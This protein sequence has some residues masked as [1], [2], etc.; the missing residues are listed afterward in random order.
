MPT[1]VFI[2]QGM[3]V[4]KAMEIIEKR[5]QNK[6]QYHWEVKAISVNG[7]NSC[8]RTIER[9]K[10]EIAKKY[11][12]L[13]LEMIQKDVRGISRGELRIILEK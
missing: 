2:S 9:I 3:T 6:E 5:I 4:R 13:E 1:L 8:I 7:L 12:K 11:P 10:A